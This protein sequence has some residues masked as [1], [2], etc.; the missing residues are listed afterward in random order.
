MMSVTVSDDGQRQHVKGSDYCSITENI[1]SSSWSLP[2]KSQ[3]VF[4]LDLRVGF[5]LSSDPSEL[6]IYELHNSNLQFVQLISFRVRI[7]SFYQTW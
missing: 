7:R 3:F 5:I 2:H 4:I 6:K 1:G